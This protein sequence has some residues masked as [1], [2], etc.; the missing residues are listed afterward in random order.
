MKRQQFSSCDQCRRS[1]RRCENSSLAVRGDV[2][3]CTNCRRHSLPCTYHFAS[4]KKQP[5][6]NRRERRVSSTWRPEDFTSRTV[7]ESASNDPV[8]TLPAIETQPTG[9]PFLEWD[10][11]N[12]CDN[13]DQMFAATFDTTPWIEGQPTSEH[14]DD[15]FLPNLPATPE[16]PCPP[17]ALFPSQSSRILEHCRRQSPGTHLEHD[18][19]DSIRPNISASFMSTALNRSFAS[20]VLE[21]ELSRI[22][23]SVFSLHGPLILGAKCNKLT[24]RKYVLDHSLDSVA[25][26][27][28]EDLP[29][30]FESVTISS[31]SGTQYSCPRLSVSTA[32]QFLDHFSTLYGHHLNKTDRDVANSALED[33]LHAFSSQWIASEVNPR[34]SAATASPEPEMHFQSESN[35]AENVDDPFKAQRTTA[36]HKANMSLQKAERIRCFKTVYACLLLSLTSV[37]SECQ[38]EQL[39]SDIQ[40]DLLKQAVHHLIPLSEAVESY[41]ELLGP[42][43]TYASNMQLSL[44][45]VG[46]F[47][48]MRDSMLSIHTMKTPIFSNWAVPRTVSEASTTQSMQQGSNEEEMEPQND[49]VDAN[50]APK[51]RCLDTSLS[52]VSRLVRDWR[53]N[54]PIIQQLMGN[55]SS[56]KQDPADC[57]CKILSYLDGY[58]KNYTPMMRESL[59]S[60]A[61]A[62]RQRFVAGRFLLNDL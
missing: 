16:P 27:R 22:Y 48:T 3:T 50:Y 38:T 35:H 33:A 34:T 37:P 54:F 12:G 29:P 4:T 51:A 61:F 19:P 18:S 5:L 24:K 55:N 44:S 8:D 17:S 36:W 10:L 1:K 62:S 41:C 57:V 58:E 31:S 46:W 47:G 25:V 43:S 32:V 56:A 42:N 28:C 20:K 9:F 40:R 30:R 21:Q 14:D 11:T 59:L 26:S 45:V 49:S 52:G 2:N 13:L 6:R 15:F 60:S 53:L 23:H 7:P 39:A